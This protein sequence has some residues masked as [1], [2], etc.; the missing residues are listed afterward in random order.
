MSHSSRYE[1]SGEMTQERARFVRK[2]RVDQDRTWRRVASEC[3][4]EFNGDWDPPNDQ[5]IGMELCQRAA[6]LF[7]ERWDEEPWN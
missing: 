7:G 2:L 6:E 5:A 3:H 1:W 4:A